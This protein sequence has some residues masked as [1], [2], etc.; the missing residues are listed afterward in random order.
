[1]ISKICQMCGKEY[2]VLP[3]RSHVKYCSQECRNQ[4]RAKA[5]TGRT[6]EKRC[7]HPKV[8]R[9]CRQCG[10]EFLVQ[11]NQVKLGKGIYCSKECKAKARDT[12]V[13]LVCAVCGKQFQKNRAYLEKGYLEKG[14]G[15]YCSRACRNKARSGEKHYKWNGGIKI[16]KRGYI[17]EYRPD[18]PF[19]NSQ[20]YVPQ[21]RLVMEKLLGRYLVPEEVVHHKNGIVTDNRPENLMLFSNNLAHLEYHKEQDMSSNG[22]R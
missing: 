10:K 18:H 1:M 19:A 13:A 20:G 16:G 7:H 6:K 22:S 11:E 2:Q 14:F 8:T 17:Y 9:V 3:S 5:S 4:A 12:R 21:H 15:K